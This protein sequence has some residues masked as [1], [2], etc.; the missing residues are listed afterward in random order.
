MFDDILEMIV[1][2]WDSITAMF[3]GKKENDTATKRCTEIK[4][5]SK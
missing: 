5:R 1:M 3:G 2:C 4:N